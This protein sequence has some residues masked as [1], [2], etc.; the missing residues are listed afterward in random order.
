[1]GFDGDINEPE[2]LQDNESDDVEVQA[3]LNQHNTMLSG[4]VQIG[5]VVEAA[6]DDPIDPGDIPRVLVQIGVVIKAASFAT[7]CP[8]PRH[9]RAMTQN[10][11][12]RSW[13]RWC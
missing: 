2:Y 6:T 5:R 9:V 8:G 12:N 7:G 13:M 4:I 1:M 11:G 10:G 3:K